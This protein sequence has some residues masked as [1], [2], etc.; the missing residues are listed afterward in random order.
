[1]ADTVERGQFTYDSEGH[2]SG[3]WNS[4][5]L[6]WPEGAS[7]VTI[8]RG[9]DMKHRTRAQVTRDLIDVGINREQA[10]R[11]ALGAGLTSNRAREFVRD[12]KDGVGE[13]TSSQQVRLFN[14]VYSTYEQTAKRVYQRHAANET[15]YTQWDSLSPDIRDIV[16][17]M[18][19]QGAGRIPSYKAAA[20]ND[21][22][23]FIQYLERRRDAE[24][25]DGER[26]RYIQRIEYLRNSNGVR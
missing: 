19:Y 2:D 10:E 4:R 22:A 13:I 25:D 15:G 11:I 1:M 26:N 21:K 17:D 18:V 14:K 16:T 9:Y 5:V 3:P 20:K 8:G 7:G 12:N 23:E 24:R 6:H